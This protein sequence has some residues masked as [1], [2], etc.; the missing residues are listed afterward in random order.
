MNICPAGSGL[1]EKTVTV[2]RRQDGKIFR[3]VLEDCYLTCQ[4]HL[5]RE[6]SGCRRERKFLLIVPGNRQ[7]L[8]GDRIFDGIGPEVTAEQWTGF[9]PVK[10]DGLMEV[11]YVKNYPGHTE[12]GR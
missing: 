9:I 11:G 5:H 8:P 3:Q 7:I 1:F 10:V 12:A 6:V 4:E 2:Y